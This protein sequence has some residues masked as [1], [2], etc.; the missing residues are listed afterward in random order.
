V[1]VDRDAFWER[2]RA[3]IAGVTDE[4]SSP[5]PD[6]KIGAVLVL[7]EDTDDGPS[8]VL[9]R[10]RRDLRSHP[11]QISFP[12]AR[13]SEG[14]SAI[15]AALR[16]ATEEVGLD[17]SSVEVIGAGPTFFVPPSRFWVVP[18]LARWE[19]PHP[20]DPNEWEVDEVIHVPIATLLDEAR[21][22]HVPLSDRGS[23]WAWQLDDDLLW[24]ATAIVMALLLEVAIEGWSGG[25]RPEDLD[26]DRAVRP[27]ETAP[28]WPLTA[29]LD[30][31][32]EVPEADVP[33]VT[34]A[35]LA[36]V[37]GRLG[38][39]TV[40]EHAGR[41]AAHAVRR[42]SGGDLAGVTVTVL[43]G[44]GANGSAGLAAAR[45]IAAA[46]GVVDVRLT[47]APLQPSQLDALRE[48]DVAVRSFDDTGPGTLL[49]DAIRGHDEPPPLD[50]ADTEALS[51][52]RR[53]QSRVVSLDLPSG[54]DPDAG[55]AGPCVSADVTVALAAPVRGVVSPMGK[56]MVGDLYLADVG[57]APAVWRAAGLAPIEAFGRGPLVRLV[58]DDGAS[59]A[60]TPDQ[61]TL[62]VPVDAVDDATVEPA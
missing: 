18:V 8:V 4:A 5:P 51:W 61:G 39:E 30:G 42:L 25:K 54:L 29:V 36:A 19:R 57:I 52:L 28:R 14:E 16:E 56:P 48:A 20:L 24:G 17:P 32:P 23:S 11:G 58:P 38:T 13:A 26:D 40:A 7:L 22:R 50:A 47:G 31:L 62:V 3:A 49:I 2:L 45:L 37:L 6:A 44:V 46:G 12:G 55:L 60:A 35:E 43:A 9:T 59:D 41:A 34:G 33:T 53:F 10:R 1:T 15:A 21:W 27:W